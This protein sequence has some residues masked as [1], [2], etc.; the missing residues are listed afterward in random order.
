MS[1]RSITR[2]TLIAT[3]AALGLAG[4]QFSPAAASETRQAAAPRTVLYQARGAVGWEKNVVEAV[5]IWNRDV[6]NVRLVEGSPAAMTIDAIDGWPYAEPTRLGRGR[7]H[8]GEEAVRDG[9]D[10]TRITAHEIGHIL[11]LPDRRTG[12]CS[13]LMSGHSAPTTCTNAHPS[14]AEAAEVERNFRNGFLPAATLA[15]LVTDCYA[16]RV[17]R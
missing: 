12:L 5:A 9:F 15:K 2:L 13:D 16:D 11:G 7:V 10:R 3:V 4:L 1:V 17:R 6:K 8:L 14:P